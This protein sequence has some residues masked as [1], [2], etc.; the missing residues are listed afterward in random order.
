MFCREERAHREDVP[1]WE[2]WRQTWFTIFPCSWLRPS[3]GP[4]V[5][6]S[7]CTHPSWSTVCLR[8]CAMNFCSEWQSGAGRGCLACEVL[9]LLS[10]FSGLSLLLLLCRSSG[11]CTLPQHLNTHSYLGIIRCL[12][13]FLQHFSLK[14]WDLTPFLL[15]L[16]FFNSFLIFPQSPPRAIVL[17]H[18]KTALGSGGS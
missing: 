7:M 10:A 12:F 3:S 16:C 1:L 17:K 11:P 8:R 9:L 2:P 13:E 18:K 4:P 6:V 14:L 5:P 15:S